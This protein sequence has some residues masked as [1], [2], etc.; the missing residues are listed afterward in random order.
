VDWEGLARAGT[1]VLF[2]ALRTLED[3]CRRLIAAGR[4]PRTPAAAIYRGTTAAQKT[5]TATLADLPAAA[6]RMKPPVLIIVGPV[7]GLREVLAW[8][9]R[10]P[11]F[12]ARVLI[13][14]NRDQAPGFVRAVTELGGEAVV[15]PVTR[16]IAPDAALDP[17]GCT[18]LDRAAA[19]LSGYDWVLFTSA[20]GVSRFFAEL[21]ARGRDSRALGRCRVACVGKATARAARDHGIIA[22][23]VPERGDGETVARALVAAPAPNAA[24]GA[25]PGQGLRVLFPRAARGRDEA[26]QVLRA[27]GARVD[28]VTV[29]ATVATPAD[30]PSL[31][32]GLARLGAREVDVIVFFAPSQVAALFALLGGDAFVDILTGC[33]VVAAIG[34][35]TGAALAER[36]VAP[37]VVAS[38]P[39]ADKL[40]AEVAV[41]YQSSTT[42]PA[43]QTGPAKQTNPGRPSAP[44]P[45]EQ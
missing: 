20:N 27:A 5:V 3:C 17:G 29:Y 35:T 12:G 33:P 24:P 18:E 4:D 8:Y 36:G 43:D 44:K 19:E 34:N 40:A 13:P 2:M 11:L 6:A 23:V 22:D 16:I 38:A 42:N 30:D 14:R 10:R 39:D 21:A 41:Y 7:V 37:D 1:V 15:M 28:V 26:A 45:K 32:A 31:S 25:E 9:E